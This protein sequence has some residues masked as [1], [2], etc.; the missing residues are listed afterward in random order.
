MI[1][2]AQVAAMQATVARAFD[3]TCNIVRPT[4]TS[5]GMGGHPTTY[6]YANPTYAASTSA[7]DTG[8]LRN[9]NN[10]KKVS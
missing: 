4:I 5:D 1:S 10:T 2:A 3:L 8:N 7:D 6:D 9:S